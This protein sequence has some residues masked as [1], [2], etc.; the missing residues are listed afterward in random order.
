MDR[1]SRQRLI[2]KIPGGYVLLFDITEDDSAHQRF[3]FGVF[4]S[5]KLRQGQACG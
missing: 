2:S 5:A 4:A 1:E 3:S